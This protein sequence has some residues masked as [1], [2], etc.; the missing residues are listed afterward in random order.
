MGK[1][2]EVGGNAPAGEVQCG[3]GAQ[4]RTGSAPRAPRTP[5]RRGPPKP[6]PAAGRRVSATA[7]AVRAPYPS[8]KEAARGTPGDESFRVGTGDAECPGPPVDGTMETTTLLL[9]VIAS[10]Y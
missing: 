2:E 10:P 5:R 4:N 3:S 1:R 9:T 8:R 7:G 6:P